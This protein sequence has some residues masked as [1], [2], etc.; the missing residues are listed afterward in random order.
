M[1]L[2]V[3]S[4][5]FGAGALL[6]AGEYFHEKYAKWSHAFTGGGLVLLY[7]TVWIAHVLYAQELAQSYSIRSSWCGVPSQ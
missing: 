4:S 3:L 1:N 7:L 5:V 6:I 2:V